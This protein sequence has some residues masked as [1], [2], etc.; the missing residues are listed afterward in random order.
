MRRTVLLIACGGAVLGGCGGG[1]TKTVTTQAPAN[2]ETTK[3]S[4]APKALSPED[5]LQISGAKF[6]ISRY[7]VKVTGYKAGQES[8]PTGVESAS[9]KRSIDRLVEVARKAP[10]ATVEASGQTVRDELLAAAQALAGGC[11]Q[12]AADRLNRTVETLPPPG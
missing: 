1:G 7:C 9:E 4:V 11:D 2:S 12:P 3:Q 6:A 8:A 10:D 5:Q